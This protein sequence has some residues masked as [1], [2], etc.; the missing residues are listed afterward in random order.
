MTGA[1]AMILRVWALYAR[2]RFV[3]GILL[4]LYAVEVV[5]YLVFGVMSSA[6]G[7]AQGV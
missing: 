7:R 3:L 2:S 6:E 4:T 1:V 5:V